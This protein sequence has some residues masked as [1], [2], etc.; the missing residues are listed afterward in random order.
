MF[1]DGA[2]LENTTALDIILDP[3]DAQHSARYSL[4]STGSVANTAH[5]RNYPNYRV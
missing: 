3:A 1:L 2:C 4:K 5:R